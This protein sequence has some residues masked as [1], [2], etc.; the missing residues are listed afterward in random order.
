MAKGHA[1]PGMARRWNLPSSVFSSGELVSFSRFKNNKEQDM[2]GKSVFFSSSL[3][4]S[5]IP[6]RN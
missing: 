3:V 4:K 2:E 1:W 6:A 5:D